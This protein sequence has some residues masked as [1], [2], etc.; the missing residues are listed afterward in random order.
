MT[1]VVRIRVST[2][3][4]VPIFTKSVISYLPEP[5]A[6]RIVGEADR[7]GKTCARGER[8]RKHER[9][10]IHSHLDR[11]LKCEGGAKRMEVALLETTLVKRQRAPQ[12]TA[13]D[14]VHEA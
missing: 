11:D 12:A 8:D 7:G 9:S 13:A 5:E 14:E 2:F 4:I 1:R 3:M 6:I 10:W